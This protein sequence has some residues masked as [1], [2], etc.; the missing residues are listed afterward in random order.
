LRDANQAIRRRKGKKRNSEEVSVILAFKVHSP[1]NVR[2]SA[3]AKRVLWGGKKELI[4][5]V[6]QSNNTYLIT[7]ICG[8][9]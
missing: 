8:G 2:A 5:S 4:G 7:H 6:A 9:T 1:E 3:K